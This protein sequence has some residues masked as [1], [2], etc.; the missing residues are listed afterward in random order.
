MAG[1]SRAEISPIDL[2][3]EELET[4]AAARSQASEEQKQHND[5]VNRE[6]L[7]DVAPIIG[8]IRSAQRANE[9]SDQ[10]AR[11]LSSG[12]WKTAARKG[13]LF[14]LDVLGTVTGMGFGNLSKAAAKGA[15]NRAGVFMVAPESKAS[16]RAYEMRDEGARNQDIA[17]ETR[18]FF[19][20]EGKLL[21]EADDYRVPVNTHMVQP[22]DVRPFQDIFPH[23]GVF[24]HLG[25]LKEKPVKILR[26][27]GAGSDVA[28]AGRGGV[29]NLPLA[30]DEAWTREQLA[31]VL[32][33]NIAEK[34]GLAKAVTHDT[35]ETVRSYVDAIRRVQ[36]VVDNPR[37]GDD[38]EAAMRWLEHAN[39]LFK[40]VKENAMSQNNSAGN[41]ISKRFAGNAVARA[42][43]ERS[44]GPA[45]KVYPF[46]QGSGDE[47][48]RGLTTLPQENLTRDELAEFLSNWRNFGVGRDLFGRP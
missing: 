4:N 30:G 11:A 5:R 2:W 13:G 29:I 21:I 15:E 8:N 28:S 33:Y 14:G 10:F 25:D 48:W 44:K 18:R 42:V 38:V 31:K 41:R 7:L 22:G 45:N 16:K 24:S 39:P 23:H 19:G 36:D 35:N 43:R 6:T 47:Q 46:N 34:Q 40:R 20:P 3:R 26:P 12:E 27:Y 1:G 9:S 17:K 32:Q 37:A